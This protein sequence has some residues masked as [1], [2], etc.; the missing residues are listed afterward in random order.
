MNPSIAELTRRRFLGQSAAGFGTAALASLLNPRLL[1]AE[2][3]GAIPRGAAL[4]GVLS[5]PHF[6]AKAKR[7]IYLCM[8]GGPSQIDLFD[9]KPKLKELDGT[10]LTGAV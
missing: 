2:K 10:E 5:Q 4:P 7:V 6:P 9:Y 8:S 3:A 1:A